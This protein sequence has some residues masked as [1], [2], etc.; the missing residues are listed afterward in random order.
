MF[1]YKSLHPGFDAVY[2]ATIW[3]YLRIKAQISIPTMSIKRLEYFLVRFY[4]NKF[5][6]LQI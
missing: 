4:T 1:V 6:G 5:P 3:D 2:A